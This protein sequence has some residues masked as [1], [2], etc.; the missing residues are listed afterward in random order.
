VPSIQPASPLPA[1]V[2]PVLKVL[3]IAYQD[4]AES[5]AVINGVTVTKGSVIEGV[6]V[7]EIQKDHVRFSSGGEKFEVFLDKSD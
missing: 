1:P 6:R 5:A 2:R 7:D 3:G 4:G